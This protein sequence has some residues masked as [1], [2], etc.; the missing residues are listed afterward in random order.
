MPCPPSI[1]FLC[2]ASR[3]SNGGTIWPAASASIFIWP[4][5]SL[6]T[7]SAKN[8]KLSCS[9]RLAGQVDCILRFF[10]CCAAAPAAKP[11]AAASATTRITGLCIEGLPCHDC[12]RERDGRSLKLECQRIAALFRPRTSIQARNHPFQSRSGRRIAL[13]HQRVVPRD[14]V[15]G[16]ICQRM[17]L[18]P[19]LAH[20]ADVVDYGERPSRLHVGVVVARVRG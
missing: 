9:V 6:S 5:V 14:D 7:R 3:I 13:Q 8:L 16:R 4:E 20:V 12:R 2:V 19:A 17:R 10:G 15:P 18:A 11:R 1:T